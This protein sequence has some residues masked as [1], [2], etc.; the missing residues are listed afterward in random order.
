MRD[1]KEKNKYSVID[2]VKLLLILGVVSIHSNVLADVE[3]Y[4]TVFGTQIEIYLSTILTRICVPS[5]FIISGYLFFH[6]CHSFTSQDY[7]RKLHRRIFTLLIPYLIW[8]VIS[9]VLQLIKIRYL[10]FPSHGL[11]EEGSIEW[12]R[13]FAG[14]FN[15]VNGYP[16]AFA[17]W[18]IRNLMVFVVLS[19]IAYLLSQKKLMIGLLFLGMCSFFNHALW[20]FSF[21]VI[22]GIIARY[23]DVLIFRLTTFPTALFGLLW[24]GISISELYVDFN[25]FATFLLFVESVSALLF[26]IT[27]MEHLKKSIEGPILRYIVPSTFFIY[28]FHQL[29]CSVTRNFY[30]GIFGLDTTAGILL[31]YLLSFITLAGLSYVVWRMLSI[32][33]PR[34]AAFLCGNRGKAKAPD[35]IKRAGINVPTL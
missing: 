2:L 31:S 1:I 15:Y 23:Y 13:V 6:N 28:A 33:S 5:F 30:I 22:G 35:T 27:M 32:L 20:G 29:F 12:S 3:D 11:I 26:L 18:F 4:P 7:L 34:V 21:F 25:Y 10:G 9:L 16:F 19:P 14:F 17:F 8:N 24:I